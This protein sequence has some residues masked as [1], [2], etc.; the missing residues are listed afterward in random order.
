MFLSWGTKQSELWKTDK[1]Y[2][3]MHKNCSSSPTAQQNY[4]W[5]KNH[6][7]RIFDLFVIWTKLPILGSQ[8]YHLIVHQGAHA[9]CLWIQLQ[10]KSG[11]WFRCSPELDPSTQIKQVT[12]E[13][14]GAST[15]PR[16]C[17]YVSSD[18]KFSGKSENCYTETR[19]FSKDL[20]WPRGQKGLTSHLTGEASWCGTGNEKSWCG[21]GGFLS[22]SCVCEEPEGFA[23]KAA[24]CLE[25][26]KSL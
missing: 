6:C 5:V 16:S 17:F 23:A 15:V 11:L 8:S 21:L 7:L 22:D 2:L 13:N 18:F 25:I 4:P 3:K 20:T 19:T 9:H 26:T 12:T 14:P 24:S 10:D 1:I